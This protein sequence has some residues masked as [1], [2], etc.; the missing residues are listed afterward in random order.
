MD[1]RVAQG[2][3]NGHIDGVLSGAE[4]TALEAHLETCPECRLLEN[5]CRLTV[6]LIASFG[7]EKAPDGF[8]Q[9]V[10]KKIENEKIVPISS[11]AFR[12]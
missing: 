8:E 2:L 6:E 9:S 5:Q 1:C 7:R 10:M 4:K 12:K 11:S 3:I